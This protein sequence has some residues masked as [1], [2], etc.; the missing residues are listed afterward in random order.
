MPLAT[1]AGESRR[2]CSLGPNSRRSEQVR[3]H[4]PAA[5]GASLRAKRPDPVG[6]VG[7]FSRHQSLAFH[8]Q[9]RVPVDLCLA[10]GDAGKGAVAVEHHQNIIIQSDTGGDCLGKTFS[11]LRD[12][13]FESASMTRRMLSYRDGSP[14]QLRIIL[15]RLTQELGPAAVRSW[16]ET[17]GAS[18]PGVDEADGPAE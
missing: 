10:V 2:S 1:L 8:P 11:K 5:P 18:G 16:R 13:G 9:I 15:R 7:E 17:Y 12:L 4:D 6:H 14:L 3:V